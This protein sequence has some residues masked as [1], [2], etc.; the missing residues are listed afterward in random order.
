MAKEL[1]LIIDASAETRSMY[2][3]YFRY[4][5]Y[6]VAEAPDAAEGVQLLSELRPDL[7][8]TELSEEPEWVEGI[9]TLRRSGTGEER[10]MI[11]CS[12]RIDPTWPCAPP[13]IDVDRAL[14]KPLSPRVLLLE[15]QAVLASRSRP[16][17]FLPAPTLA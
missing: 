1:I 5:G 2:G 7:V 6:E 4:H 17:G 12:T 16:V 8:V 9:R 14:P 10:A 15:A 11:A 3:D 13:E